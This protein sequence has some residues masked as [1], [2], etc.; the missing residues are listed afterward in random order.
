[1]NPLTLALY[2][3][4]VLQQG[5]DLPPHEE[6]RILHPED[7]DGVPRSKQW[8]AIDSKFKRALPDQFDLRRKT[9]RAVILESCPAVV[10]LDGIECSRERR[11]LLRASEE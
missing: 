3:P 5:A 4:L 8:A 9:Y 7:D 11:R 2:A 10:E 6:Y 1:M